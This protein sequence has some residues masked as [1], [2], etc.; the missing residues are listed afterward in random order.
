MQSTYGFIL[1]VLINVSGTKQAKNYSAILLNRLEI[2]ERYVHD[3]LTRPSM[4]NSS[5][6]IVAVGLGVIEV[7]GIDPQKQ[8]ITLNVNFELKWCDDL[9]QWNITEQTCLKRNRSEIFFQADEIWTPDISAV[10]GPGPMKKEARLE[11]PILVVCTGMARWSYQEK[12]VSYCEIDV[13]NFPFDR[14]YCSILIQSTIFDTSQFKLRSLYNVVRLYNYINTEWEISHTTIDEVDLYNPNHK[15]VFSTLKI[16]MELVRLSRFYVLKIILPFGIISSV[17]VFSFCLPT[18]SGEKITLTVSI[19]LSL[20]IYLQ[21]ISN[22]VPKTERGFCTLTLYSNIVFILVF[23][24]C[25]FNT[26]TIFIYYHDQYSEKH[27]APKRK[28]SILLTVHKSLMQLNKQRWIFLRKRRNIGENLPENSNIH[29][30][31]LLHNIQYFRQSLTNLFSRRNSVIT[32]TS[33]SSF[34]FRHPL[35]NPKSHAKQSARQTAVVIDRILFI[36][37]LISMSLSV[38]IL[39]QSTNRSRLASLAKT[40]RTNQLINLRKSK[41]DPVL[42]FRG[43]PH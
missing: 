15:R 25:I 29:G 18:G 31:E 13:L 23:L 43:C 20:I 5:H 36:I 42:I 28:K 33:L 19:L 39:F 16:D 40:N 11:Y 34:D 41:I 7:A 17:A 6:T 37:Y 32:A 24:S 2:T 27:K 30:I 4:K 14:Q 8:V 35:F 38:L 12:L 3:M 26:F 1:L 9:L 21:M 10:N 22:F